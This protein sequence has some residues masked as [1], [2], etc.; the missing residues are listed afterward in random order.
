MKIGILGD[1]HGNLQALT[2]AL[3]A[4]RS[5]GCDQI[6]CTGDLVGYGPRPQQCIDVIRAQNI[7]CVVGNHD[8]WMA[9]QRMLWGISEAVRAMVAWTRSMLSS[10]GR[11]FLLELDPSASFEGC[12]I[13]HASHATGEHYWPYV[14]D[15][16][17]L[18]ENFEY[19][20]V[21]VA[22]NGHTHIPAVGVFR[23]AA[24]MGFLPVA[25]EVE[26]PDGY[27]VLINPGSV[28]QPRDGDY[29]AACAVYDA[30]ARTV[31][32][33]R[34]DYPVAQTQEEMAANNLP[35]IFI[36]RI[37]VGR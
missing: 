13:V 4:L 2:R 36:E 34:V 10:E 11:K 24:E 35:Q 21:E 26:L 9:S 18:E 15:A 16:M 32:F 17:T 31:R 22:F 1:I 29:R 5:E 33:L 30:D 7:P 37:A 12:G 27:Q 3:H 28:G 14:R 25:E 20:Q 23:D 19:Q 8:E 6:V